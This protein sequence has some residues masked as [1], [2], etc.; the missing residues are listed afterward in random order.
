MKSMPTN[1][2]SNKLSHWFIRLISSFEIYKKVRRTI[3]RNCFCDNWHAYDSK[4]HRERTEVKD[5]RNI[6]LFEQLTRRLNELESHHSNHL[7]N[8]VLPNHA[9]RLFILLQQ[10]TVI[11]TPTN[12]RQCLPILDKSWHRCPPLKFWRWSTMWSVVW[13]MLKM[14]WRCRLD[15]YCNSWRNTG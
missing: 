13:L 10:T 9:R 5:Q 3:R 15:H 2:I 12:N 14:A 11:T 7:N 4:F 1:K 8:Q 6:Q